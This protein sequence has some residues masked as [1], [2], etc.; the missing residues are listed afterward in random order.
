MNLGI[1][2]E[3]IAGLAINSVGKQDKEPF[4]LIFAS[5]RQ[6]GELVDSPACLSFF[7]LKK[8]NTL[9]SH[10]TLNK[11]ALSWHLLKKANNE[12]PKGELAPGLYLR[13]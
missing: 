10:R 11:A 4:A 7:S 9:Q 2:C 1:V 5:F 13:P 12:I 8:T 6:S 3:W